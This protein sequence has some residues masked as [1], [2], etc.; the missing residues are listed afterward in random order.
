MKANLSADPVANQAIAGAA[1][2][3]LIEKSGANPVTG[4]FSQ[5]GWNKALKTDIDPKIDLLL[6][7]KS[8]QHVQAL[9]RVAQLT[10]AQPRGSYVNNSNTLV[11]GMKEV[12]KAGAEFKTNLAFGGLPVGTGIRK[13]MEAL[14]RR[15]ALKNTLAPAAGVT[16]ISDLP[17]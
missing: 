5:A 12:G 8:A 7:P 13:G 1:V 11:A 10:Q 16:K 17:R 6:D 4:N 2:N 14:A 9:G 3:H 15:N